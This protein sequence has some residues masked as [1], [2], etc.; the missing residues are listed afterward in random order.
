MSQ[1]T[2][3]RHH[4]ALQVSI[5]VAEEELD[6]ALRAAHAGFTLSSTRVTVAVVGATGMVGQLLL[7]QLSQ[8]RE[9]TAAPMLDAPPTLRNPLTHAHSL[10]MAFAIAALGCLR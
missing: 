1:A 3:P 10:T 2:T 4:G 9:A 6:R 5:V 8:Q 7:K